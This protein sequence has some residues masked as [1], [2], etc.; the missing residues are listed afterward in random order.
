MFFPAKGVLSHA[1]KEKVDEARV[2]PWH[3]GDAG[4]VRRSYCAVSKRMVAANGR[5]YVPAAAGHTNGRFDARRTQPVNPD[6]LG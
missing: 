3:S 2:M 4:T 6:N 5:L 1:R